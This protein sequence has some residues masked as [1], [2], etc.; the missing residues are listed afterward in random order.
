[1]DVA[2]A[3]EFTGLHRTKL[4]ELAYSGAVPSTKVGRRRLF[5]RLGLVEHL[6]AAAGAATAK[7][8]APA[9]TGPCE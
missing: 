9:A 6:R 3:A 5:A 7:H 2:A 1:M 4:L 8:I